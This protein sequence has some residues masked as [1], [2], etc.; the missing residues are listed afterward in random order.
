MRQR[1]DQ[2][3]V[4]AGLADSRE[5]AQRLILAGEVT[6]DGQK[7]RKA[8]QPVPEGAALAL[9]AKPRFV[10]RGG[11]KL[12]GAFAAFPLD[13]AGQCCLD[14]GAS[15]G[16]F[17][18]C[19]LQHGARRFVILNGHGGND[20]AIEKAGLEL[21]RETGALITLL[22]WWGIAPE[23]N[24]AWTTGHG[25]AQE[26]SAIMH[27]KPELIDIASCPQ[28]TVNDLSD[29]LH[30]THLS[31]VK[32]ADAHIKLIRDIKKGIPMGGFGGI[33]SQKAN[34]QWGKEMLDAVVNYFVELTEELRRV[35]LDK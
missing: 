11:E 10:S 20:P 29:K 33:D 28:T 32:F 2:A 34:A 25:D 4:A 3:L 12:E 27:I 6:V 26:V 9:L 7:A 13:V 21:A 16:G 30:F 24:K 8:S 19:L 5:L 14:V 1:L 35:P 31:S 22:D 18:D 23:L 15:T 17:T